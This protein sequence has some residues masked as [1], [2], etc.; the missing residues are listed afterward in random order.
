[1]PRIFAILALGQLVLFASVLPAQG[2]SVSSSGSGHS[3]ARAWIAPLGIVVS[4]ALDPEVREWAQREHSHSL[5]S[6]AKSVN[7]LGT[8]RTL[9]PGM[10]LT[11]GAALLTHHESLASGTLKT[12]AAYIASDLAES[13]LKPIIGRER[14][15]VE[16]NSHRFHPFTTN[17]DWHSLPSAH[18]A[19]IAAIAQAVS[20]Q[21][22]STP[23]TAVCSGLVALVGWD[24]VYEDQHWTSDVTATIALTGA[25]SRSVVHWLESRGARH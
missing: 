11:Y 17:G 25:V 20:M 4:A 8:A 7:R 21:T 2:D 16:G 15:H 9:V 23:V 22:N 3:S 24:R 6:L 1:M 19:H 5:N 10:A 13:A 18:V 12:A 14:P